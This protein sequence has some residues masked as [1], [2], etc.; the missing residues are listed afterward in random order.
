MHHRDHLRPCEG[1][2][3]ECTYCRK[4]Y[5]NQGKHEVL[6]TLHREVY[7]ALSVRSVGDYLSSN[8]Q[9]AL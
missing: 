8:L 4:I 3:Y 9:R 1:L 5:L 6:G 2:K 7:V